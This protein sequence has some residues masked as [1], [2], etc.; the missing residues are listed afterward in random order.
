MKAV[1]VTLAILLALGLVLGGVFYFA[2]TH[3]DD[4]IKRAIERVGS[5]MLQTEV[6]VQG[7][8][9]QLTKGIGEIDALRIANPPGYSADNFFRLDTLSLQIEPASLARDVYVIKELI[10]DGAELTIEHKNLRET[11]LQTLLNNLNSKAEGEGAGDASGG[12]EPLFAIERLTF[13]NARL[14]LISP[15]F[16]P[17]SFALQD[18]QQTDIGS[19]TEGLTARELAIAVMQPLL[20]QAKGR[21][22]NALKQ[23]LGDE[24]NKRLKNLFRK[25]K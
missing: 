4:F 11:N 25:T 12:S 22:E 24:L 17:Q 7:T 3:F 9:F 20:E 6:S 1:K 16:E 21:Y 14:H 10:I 8:A 18:I 5:D 2:S 13:V 15:A 19:P 23:R